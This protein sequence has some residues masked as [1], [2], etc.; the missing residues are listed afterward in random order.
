MSNL[1]VEGLS[2]FYLLS[3]GPRPGSPVMLMESQN[4]AVGKQIAQGLL[5]NPFILYV[6]KKK[7][8]LLEVTK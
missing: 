5:L 6:E 8:I 4:I 7:F 1:S 3:S 2:H